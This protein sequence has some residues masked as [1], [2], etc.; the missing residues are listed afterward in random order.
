MTALRLVVE[1]FGG[2][3]PQMMGDG[4]MAVFGVPVA[5]EDDAERAVRAA[6]AIRDRVESLNAERPT[7]VR[8]PPVHSGLNSGDV[9]VSGSREPLGF[10]ITGDTV[11]TAS[12]LAGVA[13][14][15][16][17]VVG[18]RTRDL[19]AHAIAYGPR[20]TR[21]V[22]GKPEGV[23]AFEALSITAASPAGRVRRDV[24]LP[25]FDRK[26]A[27]ARLQEE[28]RE[29]KRSKRSRVI[30]V[31]GEPGIGKS[32]LAEE[33][34]S[35]LRGATWLPGRC[36]PYGQHLPLFAIADAMRWLLGLPDGSWRETDVGIRERTEPLV[37]G[38]TERFLRQVR[39]LTGHEDRTNPR[40]IGTSEDTTVAARSA[41]EALGRRR[42]VVVQIDDLQ[43]ADPD[44]FDLLRDANEEPWDVPV[45]FL[46]LVRHEAPGATL[47]LP[48]IRI[49]ALPAGDM[50][51]LALAVVGSRLPGDVAMALLDR[52]GGNP[53]FLQEG[54][55]ML[56]ESNALRPVDGAWA[57][58]DP[59]ALARVPESLR[60]LV[61]ARID[62]LAHSE[63]SVLQDASVCGE[64]FGEGLLER[65]RRKPVH[66]EVR[67]LVARDLLV[68][69][70]ASGVLGFK[71]RVVRDVTYDSLPKAER[72]T[73][74]HEVGTWLRDR[75][76]ED[77]AAIAYHF[78]RA[79]TLGRSKAAPAGDQRAA[80]E[81]ATWLLQAGA[82]AFAHRPDAA[83][84][85][86]STAASAARAGDN[87]ALLAEALA[88][89]AE[90]LIELGRHAAAARDA[91]RARSLAASVG[92]DD[93]R[94]RA[95]LALGRHASDLSR[96][97]RAKRLLHEALTL[98]PA[99]DTQARA[100]TQQRLSEAARFEPIPAQLAP[101]RDALPLF[102]RAGDAWGLA[103]IVLDM[104]YLLSIVGGTEYREALDRAQ[105]LAKDRADPRT[106]ASVLRTEA[107][108]AY[109][110]RRFDVAIRL[111]RS[112]Q[113]LGHAA[114]DR[115]L[116]VE[117]LLLETLATS[118]SR[119][120]E[121]T[122]PLVKRLLAIADEV[123]TRHLRAIALSAGARSS[124][125][126]GR[127]TQ[128]R[129]RV[130]EARAILD[131][132][133]AEPTI[134]EVEIVE[135]DL[136]LALGHPDRAADAAD[137]AA[138]R[139]HAYGYTLLERWARATA[140][141]A[142]TAART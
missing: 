87:D 135:A 46:G 83:E 102:E 27:H 100:W 136:Q 17:V 116:E 15:G 131:E 71:H 105:R 123:G 89:R 93:L 124:L 113:P 78:E 60:A 84:E 67:Q 24:E 33:F 85:L 1:D 38:N 39:L 54:A 132:L 86:F 114:G 122:E 29:A 4:F 43:W 12:R 20:R 6:L 104:A 52:A 77:A 112:A 120:S 32:R 21:K 45:L 28:F 130:N 19:T 49:D 51:D 65:L 50:S 127:T 121:E 58:A 59:R 3:V 68:R 73:R 129:R 69:R 25:F 97:A 117:S 133:G 64:S 11:N 106:E 72:A 55:R 91:S 7:G 109:Y 134:A 18:E 79:W 119:P 48:A 81:A 141:D 74:H 142:R 139:A 95:L 13:R 80:C 138:E 63:K 101:L 44:V 92:R 94:A 8:V 56:V 47:D 110:A 82:A 41:I 14:A 76:D 88:G 53:L 40:A 5:H 34:R 36:P 70:D 111:A 16:Q 26:E 2:V 140:R 137:R 30:V 96:V 35:S 10:E 107:S 98:L 22:K 23:A 90:S 99:D 118:A 42:P 125:A 75:G 62:G 61:A 115:W 57:L 103:S 37:R 108:H 66:G 128:A 126:G 31:E 9:L